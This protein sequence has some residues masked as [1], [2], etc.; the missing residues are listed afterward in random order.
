MLTFK[1][2]KKVQDYLSLSKADLTHTQQQSSSLLGAWY[3]NQLVI[4]RRKVFLFMNEK[5]LLSFIALGA[6]KSRALKQDFPAIFLLQ[7]FHLMK[8][9]ELPIEKSNQ[10]IDDY[11]KSEFRKT[12]SRTVLGN[13][14]ELAKLYEHAI[15]FHGGFNHC[16]ISEIIYNINKTPQRNLGWAYSSDIA[17]EILNV[18]SLE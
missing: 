2:T 1:C 18:G 14:S 7:F 6:K 15:Y 3:V 12:D 4:D 13:L 9:L 11:F 17:K 5:T 16:D 8:L 10:L